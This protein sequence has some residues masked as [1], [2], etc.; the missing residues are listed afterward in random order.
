MKIVNDPEG[1]EQIFSTG[2]REVE[3]AFGDGTLLVE[4]YLPRVRHVEVQIAGHRFQHV[5]LLGVR[6]CSIQRR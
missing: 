4:K 1:F 5:I 2:Q 3:A 6:D